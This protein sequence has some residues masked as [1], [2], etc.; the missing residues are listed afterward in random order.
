MKVIKIF[1]LIKAFMKKVLLILFGIIIFIALVV[2]AMFTFSIC[3]PKGPW[4]MPPWCGSGFVKYEYK[5]NVSPSYLTQIK[6]VN[7]YDTWGRNYNM[8][9]VET[10]QA[11]IESSFDRVKALGASEVYVHDFDR[12]VYNKGMDF[13]SLDYQLVD[14][15][16]LNDMRDESINASDL[17]KLVEGAHSRG[18]KLGIKRNLA[19]VDI[20]KYIVDGVK[21]DISSSVANDYQKFNESHSEEWIKDY[22]QKWQTRL[23]EKGRMYQ[24]AGV[25]I[26]SISPSFQ[27]P[28]FAGQEKLANEEWKNL[29]NKLREVFKGKIMVDMNIYGLIDGNNGKEDWAQYDYYKNADIIEVKVYSILN[30]YWNK[31][32]RAA[33]KIQKEIENMVADINN[34]A[35]D[36]GIKLSVF[37]APSSYK[38]GIFDGPVE[39]L[40]LRNPKIINLE[41]DYEEQ[42]NAFNYFFQALKDKNNIERINAGNFAWDDA[43]DPEV[44]PRISIAAGFRNKAAEEVVKTWFRS[45]P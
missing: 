38:N 37:Y 16:F 13:S 3:P 12:A 6:A 40:D 25:D 29:I 4:P 45:A 11:N 8:N 7:M 23:I 22:F 21:G 18:M 35:G 10:T 33:E 27:D 31:D 2:G 42:V 44:K 14:E 20:G 43:L 32:G 9:M 17:K 1:I 36:L 34:R 41:K 24:E 30:K 26:M 39:F 28:T 5:V 19:F 15:I